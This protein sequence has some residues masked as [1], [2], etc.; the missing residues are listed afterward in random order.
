MSLY[1]LT[2]K[3]WSMGGGKLI[4]KLNRTLPNLETIFI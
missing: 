2:F 3:D 4:E 1:N